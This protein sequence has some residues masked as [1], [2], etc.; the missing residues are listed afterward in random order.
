[1]VHEDTAEAE[2]ERDISTEKKFEVEI[3]K[4]GETVDEELTEVPFE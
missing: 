3:S 4:G 2:V 1:V